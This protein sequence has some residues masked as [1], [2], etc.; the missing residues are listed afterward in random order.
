MTPDAART[1]KGFDGY[2]YELVFSDEFETDGRSFYPGDDPFWEAQDI[3][4]GA[5]KDLE[6]YDPDNVSTKDGK[7]RIK[8]ELIDDPNINHNLTMKSGMLTGW[9]KFCFTSGYIESE[10]VGM[11]R[12]LA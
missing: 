12:R 4:Y 3:W 1:R 8:L 6:W 9:N 5:T 2:E 10:C 7:L 11:Q